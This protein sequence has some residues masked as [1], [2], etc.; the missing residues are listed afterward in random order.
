MHPIIQVSIA[1]RKD[2][3]GNTALH[4]AKP[5]PNQSIAKTLLSYGAKLDVNPQE[6]INLNEKTLEEWFFDKCVHT[7]GDDVD[8]E[9]KS[10]EIYDQNALVD[11]I[12]QKGD[13][14]AYML[15][16]SCPT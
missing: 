16:V 4:Y 12:H 11:N 10:I 3:Y 7:E 1:Y 14:Q 13:S 6:M 5:Y 9:V 15:P 8:D 2:M